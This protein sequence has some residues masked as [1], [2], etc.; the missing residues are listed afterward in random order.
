MRHL[1]KL[2][3]SSAADPRAGWRA[4]INEARTEIEDLLED[5]PSLRRETEAMIRK[6]LSIAARLAADDL[7]THGEAAKAIEERLEGRGYTA[8]QVLGDWFPDGAC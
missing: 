3:V 1:L 2:E 8:E 7:L 5:S 4:T 6:Q